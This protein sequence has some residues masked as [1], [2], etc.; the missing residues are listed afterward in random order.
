[1]TN[2]WI[3]RSRMDLPSASLDQLAAGKWP[4]YEGSQAKL[5]KAGAR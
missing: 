5:V 1:M 2:Y 3:Y 4:T